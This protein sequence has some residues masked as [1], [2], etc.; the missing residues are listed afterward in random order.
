MPLV[1]YKHNVA[2]HFTKL[3]PKQD[4][5]RLARFVVDTPSSEDNSATKMPSPSRAL[6]LYGTSPKQYYLD[7]RGHCQ[8]LD[9]AYL[10]Y[11]DDALIFYDIN[12]H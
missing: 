4:F 6:H 5:S 7:G 3:L 2:D 10:H 11:A 1:S 8:L 9:L 12:A